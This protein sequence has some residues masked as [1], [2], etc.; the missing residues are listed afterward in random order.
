MAADAAHNP[1]DDADTPTTALER[2][3]FMLWP[4]VIEFSTLSKAVIQRR[5]KA[6]DFPAPVQLSPNRV[7]WLRDEV[8]AWKA[9][10]VAKR[11]RVAEFA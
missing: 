5:V 10:L 11:A 4:E 8:A 9:G 3:P 6:G 7:A 2:S 1:A